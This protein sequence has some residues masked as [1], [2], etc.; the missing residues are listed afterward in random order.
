MAKSKRVQK[1]KESEIS[2]VKKGLKKKKVEEEDTNGSNEKT[3]ESTT[4]ATSPDSKKR[5]R[6]AET[7][8][9]PT[10]QTT[11]GQEKEVFVGNI[12][13]NAKLADFQ[14]L[15]EKCGKVVKVDWKTFVQGKFRGFC[16]VQYATDADA[17]K[18]VEELNDKEVDGRK[19]KVS[20][21]NGLPGEKSPTNTIFV[22][23]F[24]NEATIQELTELFSKYGKVADAFFSSKKS[25]FVKFEEISSATQAQRT[26]LKFRSNQLRIAFAK[27]KKLRKPKKPKQTPQEEAVSKPVETDS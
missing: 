26:P 4:A 13:Y 27:D 12:A 18:A 14:P 24:P 22:D 10:N 8:N 9:P 20:I 5:K 19:L 6:K 3:E 16:Y 17:Q 1:T 25:A 2:T 11:T 21:S 7:P 15:F 23:N